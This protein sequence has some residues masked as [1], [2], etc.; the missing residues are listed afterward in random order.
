[1][2]ASTAMVYR[3]L[4]DRVSADVPRLPGRRP[5]LVDHLEPEQVVGLEFRQ[6]LDHAHVATLVELPDHV[7]A[8]VL[9]I[10]SERPPAIARGAM[11]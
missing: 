7:G 6:H 4:P 5:E 10:L 9:H 3:L 11:T 1:V 8:D 2:L